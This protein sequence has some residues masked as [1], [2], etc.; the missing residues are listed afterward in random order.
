MTGGYG[1]TY[2]ETLKKDVVNAIDTIKGILLTKKI[3]LQQYLDN[4]TKINIYD[5]KT[6]DVQSGPQKITTSFFASCA[7]DTRENVVSCTLRRSLIDSSTTIPIESSE[8]QKSSGQLPNKK[9]LK[10]NS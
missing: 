1:T 4:K 2:V 5:N 6:Q 3:N 8:R 10:I 7:Q 9:R